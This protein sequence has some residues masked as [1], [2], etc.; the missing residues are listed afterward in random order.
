MQQSDWRRIS[1]LAR[2]KNNILYHRTPTEILVQW[3]KM[4]FSVT[5]NTLN[6]ILQEFF[7]D[8]AEKMLGASETNPPKGGFGWYL[9]DRFPQYTPRHASAIAAIMC[10]LELLEHRGKCPV[11]LKRKQ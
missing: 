1:T 2:T 9:H 10:D 6:T 8:G 4:K 11:Y 5:A 3:S 7:S